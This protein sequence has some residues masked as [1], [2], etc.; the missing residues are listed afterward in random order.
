VE[1]SRARR[2]LAKSVGVKAALSDGGRQGGA[3]LAS[4]RCE[5]R[6]V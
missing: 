1:E 4:V 2:L 6:R 5:Q 3:S